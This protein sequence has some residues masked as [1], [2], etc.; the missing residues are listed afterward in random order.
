MDE[1]V[2]IWAT[3][4]PNVDVGKKEIK[5]ALEE[6]GEVTELTVQHTESNPASGGKQETEWS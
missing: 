6:F 4:K 2:K 1:K 3:V 5:D